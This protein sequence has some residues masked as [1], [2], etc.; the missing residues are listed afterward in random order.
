M[1]TIMLQEMLRGFFKED[2]GERDVTSD[3]LLKKEEKG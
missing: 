3:V 2:M 1:N